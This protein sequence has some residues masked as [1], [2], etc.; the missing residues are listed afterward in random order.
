MILLVAR[1]ALSVPVAEMFWAPVLH[2]AKCVIK[3]HHRKS[4]LSME[5]TANLWMLTSVISLLLFTWEYFQ[6]L[7]Q[8]N[9]KAMLTYIHPSLPQT[10]RWKDLAVT[11][12][13]CGKRRLKAEVTIHYVTNLKWC[14]PLQYRRGVFRRRFAEFQ[15]DIAP[16]ASRL[17]KLTKRLQPHHARCW[18]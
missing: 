10:C 3:A 6:N 5:C 4:W 9:W 2:R 8:I 7:L 1:L 15:Q 13:W 16:T 17:Q 18:C 11:C 14:I 12:C